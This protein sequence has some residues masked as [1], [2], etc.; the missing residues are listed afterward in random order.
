M[1]MDLRLLF[2]LVRLSAT[3][4]TICLVLQCGIF[5]LCECG[6][7]DVGGIVS[8]SSGTDNIDWADDDDDPG[9]FHYLLLYWFAP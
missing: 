6:V 7:S 1:T 8:G 4:F 9:E 2:T 3:V 5:P